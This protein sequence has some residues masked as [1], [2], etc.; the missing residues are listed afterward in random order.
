MSYIK[1]ADLTVEAIVA[2]AF[3]LGATE[4]YSDIRPGW[5]RRISIEWPFPQGREYLC[6][7]MESSPLDVC[8]LNFANNLPSMRKYV[9]MWGATLKQLNA[10]Q[11]AM[12]AGQ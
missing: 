3:A 10:Y 8:D 12:E 2:R 1:N 7:T 6:F 11:K 4:I 9:E 5:R